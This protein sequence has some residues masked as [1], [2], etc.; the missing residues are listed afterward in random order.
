MILTATLQIEAKGGLTGTPPKRLEPAYCC[1]YVYIYIYY[2]YIYE[3]VFPKIKVG[4]PKMDG[5]NNGEPYL[6]S[7]DLGGPPL[8][9]ETPIYIYI[10]C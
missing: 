3:W 1:M 9:L 4:P 2:I 10:H 6:N 5:E 8:L 7:M